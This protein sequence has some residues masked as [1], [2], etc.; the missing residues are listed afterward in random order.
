MGARCCKDPEPCQT[1]NKVT[2]LSYNIWF[3]E[4]MMKERMR[5][6]GKI[7]QERNPDVV[8]LNEV[9]RENLAMLR[10][11]PW[12]DSYNVLPTDIQNQNSYFVVLLTK[13]MIHSWKIY[14]FKNSCFGRKL[15]IA[16]LR[17][18]IPCNEKTKVVSLTIATS[19][20]ESLD[21][22]TIVREQQL[23]F[24]LR[25][26]SCFNNAC[27]MGDLNIEQKVDGD[28]NLPTPW[29]DAWLSIVGNSHVD[30]NG[31]TWDPTINPMNKDLSCMEQNRLD[32]IMCKLCDFRV[33][34]VEI[35]GQNPL[36][37]GVF[38]SDHF[39][40]LAVFEPS[41]ETK[42]I[43]GTTQTVEGEPEFKRPTGW[44]KFLRK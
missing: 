11:Q 19:H 35:V 37:P 10:E 26:L 3:G 1:N 34:N 7:I 6:I 23:K 8:A 39:G 5:G 20:L 24:S 13:L 31:Y 38:P 40:V 36:A 32:R 4:F 12:F 2:V 18:R 29:F 44:E 27:L 43:P 30:E 41:T 25:T 14:P 33:R 15:L 42:Q 22:N 17:V 9:T 21:Y 28:V 16:E